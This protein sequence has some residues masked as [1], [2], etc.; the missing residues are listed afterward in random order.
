MANVF[1]SYT[2]FIQ[3]VWDQ[4][5]I[6]DSVEQFEASIGAVPRPKLLIYAT[7]FCL[8][9]VYNGG[10]LQLFFN[11][12]GILTPEAIAGFDLIGMPKLAETF[13]KASSVL[14]L[15]FPRDRDERQSSMIRASKLGDAELEKIFKQSENLYLSYLGATKSL[16]FDELSEQAWE[17]A[18]EENGGFSCGATAYANSIASIQ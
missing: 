13:A 2:D 18:D 9:E 1:E 3:E 11:S 14:G 17:L 8:S 15:P 10:F 16:P 12:T 6:Y 5:N 7:N 4:V